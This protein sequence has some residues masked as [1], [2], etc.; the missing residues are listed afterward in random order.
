M[1]SL[2]PKEND[3]DSQL[4]G[5]NLVNTDVVRVICVILLRHCGDN[6]RYIEQ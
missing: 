1:D 6:K 5:F 4:V 3:S 2:L